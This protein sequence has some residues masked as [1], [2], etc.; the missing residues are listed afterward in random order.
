MKHRLTLVVACFVSFLSFFA[1]TQHE[2]KDSTNTEKN[3]I[4]EQAL[5]ATIEQGH[6]SPMD[7]NDA[8]SK[9][10][11]TEYLKNL[12]NSKMFFLQQEIDK[13]SKHENK[14]DDEVR[15]GNL[16]LF[17]ESMSVYENRINEIKAWY[18]E[19]LNTPIDLNSNRK[20]ETNEEKIAYAKTQ[21][22]LKTRWSDYLTFQIIMRLHDIK[23]AQDKALE[24]KDTVITKKTMTEMEIE[25]RKKTLDN[26]DKW[27]ER[28]QKMNESQKLEIFLNSMTSVFDP[29]TN[30]YAPEEKKSF[31][32]SM[33]GQ[34]EGIGARLQ[35]KD[36]QVQVYEVIL[37]GPAYRSG[38]V[39]D[40]D[41][42]LSVA[43]GDGEMV[44]I[45]NY[46]VNDA[47]KLIR[48]KKGTKVR[49]VLKHLDG[50][51]EE[52]ILIRDVVQIDETYAK[53]L[54]LKTKEKQHPIGYIYLPK[55]YADFNK[56][57]GRNC[58]DDIKKE[59]VK[60]KEENV[61]CII[62]DL[63]D[64]G[65]GSLNDC[66]NMVGH[67]IDKGPVVQVK[68]TGGSIQALSDK[69]SGTVY[70]GKMIVLT[71]TNSASA[72]EILAAAMQDYG[73]A[74]IVGSNNTYGK[75]TVQRFVNLDETLPEKMLETYAPLGS[76]KVTIQK[77]YRING[78]TTQ[79]H[80]VTPDIVLPDAYKYIDKGEAENKNALPFD[81]VAK[82]RYTT[83]SDLSDK[84]RLLR[85]N[86]QRRV[87]NFPTLVAINNRADYLKKNKE[88]SVF[89]LNFE[90]YNQDEN[91]RDKEN[92]SYKNEFK[93]IESIEIWSLKADESTI[94]E[95]EDTK[96][97][98]QKWTDAIKKDAILYETLC[99]ADDFVT[100]N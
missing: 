86:S 74:I 59:V 38:K 77:F 1:F 40:K 17:T 23:N 98:Y 55:F 85:K 60:L 42:I 80:G 8:F 72:S 36:G 26:Q 4:L 41:I 68:S 22:E 27:F 39:K 57:N 70:N 46:D 79:L 88:N 89:P 51:T 61:S 6:F 47:V 18:K 37:G 19:I 34:L 97:R 52:V 35:P 3:K 15:E 78:G 65:G 33:S 84:I 56:I 14:I 50:T 29:H 54:I 21:D 20:Y 100:L 58:A 44:D 30:Y 96:K 90:L 94:N 62:L 82:A 66:V 25:A 11:Y 48:G 75:G 93:P 31:D 64:N 7:I 13:F 12:D 67:F 32:I 99:I 9:K 45:S 2:K 49:L 81:E 5:L 28:L 16:S 43:Q 10:V 71:N 76:L 83:V 73:R 69:Y 91:V 53:S 92:E 87:K 95:N 24:K 63:R